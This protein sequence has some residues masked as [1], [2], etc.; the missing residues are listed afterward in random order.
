MAGRRFY[1]LK[2]PEDFFRRGYI[3]RLRGM[4]DGDRLAVIYLEMLLASLKTDGTLACGPGEDFAEELGL[5]LY[6][7]PAHVE[8]VLHYVSEKGKLL[9]KNESEYHLTD[10][11]EMTGSETDSARRKREE[12]RRDTEQTPCAAPE[13]APPAARAR[14][15]ITDA[16]F[17]EQLARLRRK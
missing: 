2:L 14:C 15:G 5:E 1:W 10:S 4:K 9:S 6:E 8:T 13:S 12:R 17:A 16:E 11:E 3:R 7:N